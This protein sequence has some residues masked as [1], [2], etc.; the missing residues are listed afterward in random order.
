[1]QWE[2]I[3]LQLKR[4]GKIGEIYNIDSK[5]VILIKKFLN[6]LIR[7]AQIEIRCEPDKKLFKLK[8]IGIKIRDISK[9]IRHTDWRPKDNSSKSVDKLLNYCICLLL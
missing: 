4:K 3:C 6:I 2:H 7:V 5:K 8:D 9:F 1:M